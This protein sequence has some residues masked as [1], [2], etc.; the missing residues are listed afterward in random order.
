[1]LFT[2][3][4]PMGSAYK[5]TRFKKLSNQSTPM[6]TKTDRRKCN[7]RLEENFECV[8]NVG[9]EFSSKPHTEQTI[10]IGIQLCLPIS[11]QQYYLTMLRQTPNVYRSLWK[12]YIQFFIRWLST[13]FL[14]DVWYRRDKIEI[15][16][17]LR[18]NSSN[19]FYWL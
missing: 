5:Y 8:V 1:M 7:S 15:I 11:A 16:F 9:I 12:L 13:P 2:F 6:P 19:S 10:L 3:R 14:C 4:L 18:F 17:R